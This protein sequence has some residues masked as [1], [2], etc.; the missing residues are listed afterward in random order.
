MGKDSRSKV[1]RIYALLCIRF[2]FL[3]LQD[4]MLTTAFD[5]E[6][7]EGKHRHFL[8]SEDIPMRKIDSLVIFNS[9]D[10]IGNADDGSYIDLK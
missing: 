9:A 3:E 5:L 8:K 1:L 10:T 2:E 4:L 6:T 7:E